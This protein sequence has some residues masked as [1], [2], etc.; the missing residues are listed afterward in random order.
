MENIDTTTKIKI[1]KKKTLKKRSGEK[2]ESP[3]A[4]L[5]KEDFIIEPG[6]TLHIPLPIESTVV[7]KKYC[8]RGTRKNIKTGIC[9]PIK[10]VKKSPEPASVV[11]TEPK[12]GLEHGDA[13][14]A[15]E[16]PMINGKIK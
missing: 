7:K 10:N 8:P 9:E 14:R 13:T 3:S 16:I 6:P 5:P 1:P 15:L 11:N 2:A 4:T 12:I